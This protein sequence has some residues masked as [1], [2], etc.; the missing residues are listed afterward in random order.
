MNIKEFEEL[1]PRPWRVIQEEDGTQSLESSNKFRTIIDLVEV[2]KYISLL[3]EDRNNLQK[4]L[5]KDSELYKMIE[6]AATKALEDGQIFYSPESA[7][8][9]L[10]EYNPK[11][12]NYKEWAV[13][14]NIEKYLYD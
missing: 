12:H 8:H 7:F 1:Y 5:D 6:K 2:I 10:T 14:T 4:K 11:L 9:V 3:Q 13:L